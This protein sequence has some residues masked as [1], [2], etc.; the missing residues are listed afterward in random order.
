MNKDRKIVIVPDV[1]GRRFWEDVK[2][3]TADAYEI[4]FLGDYVDPYGYEKDVEK[5]PKDL[6]K[7]FSDIITFAK[8]CPC[9]CTLLFGNHDLHYLYQ[10]DAC[11]RF[12]LWIGKDFK[13]LVNDNINLFKFAHNIDN[14]LFTHA[15]VSNEWLQYNTL[16]KEGQTAEDIANIINELAKDESNIKNILI[17]CSSIRGGLDEYSGPFWCDSHE[18]DSLTH[19]EGIKQF[20]GHTQIFGE[21]PLKSVDGL[22]DCVDLRRIIKIKI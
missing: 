22:C 11:S 1:H 7:N 21:A 13:N 15:G 18:H 8:Y 20:F 6:L 19:P 10:I 14:I 2:N 12:D 16:F 5:S 4:V 9:K 17:Q 3:E